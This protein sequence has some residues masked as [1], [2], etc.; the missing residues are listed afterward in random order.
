ML[1]QREI[2]CGTI[3]GIRGRGP[4]ELRAVAPRDTGRGGGERFGRRSSERRDCYGRVS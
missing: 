4:G 2:R 3:G 1:S